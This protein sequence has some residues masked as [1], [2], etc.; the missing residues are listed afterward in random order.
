MQ[1]S[2]IQEI[3]RKDLQLERSQGELR[4]PLFKQVSLCKQGG[5]RVKVDIF[6]VLVVSIFVARY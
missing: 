3:G 1:K 2:A 5:V 6:L 4:L